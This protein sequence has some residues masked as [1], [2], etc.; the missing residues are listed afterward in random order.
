MK[1]IVYLL[2]PAFMLPAFS[3]SQS[4]DSSKPVS[5]LG[6]TITATQNGISLIPSFSLGK[7]AI[8]FDLNAG[9]SK[10]TFEP[11]FRFGTDGKPWSFIFW[12]RYK[13]V[14]NKKFRMSAGAHP[15]YVFR[16]VTADN[17]GTKEKINRAD[18]YA[19][20]DIAPN[21]FISPNTS[22]GIYYL[23]SHGLDKTSVQNTHFITLNANFTH[24]KLAG[25]FYA[26]FNP[27]VYYLNQA[28]RDGFYFTHSL[29][30]A[31]TNSP[32]SIQTI[33]NKVIRTNISGHDFVWNA[34][35]IY[36]FNKNYV[37]HK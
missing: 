30:L 28:G 32:F 14:N 22:I 35:L 37:R 13:L 21:Y 6:G 31:H 18:R 17:N 9:G 20:V 33:M 7:P 23:Y 3:Y 36:H 15:S 10:L 8:M 2:L 27:Q 4:K 5:H 29:T 19:A 34:S 24:I 11:F 12:W 25:R 1:K 16:S 26:K